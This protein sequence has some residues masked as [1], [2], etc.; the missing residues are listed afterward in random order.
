M[1]IFSL[2][3][4]CVLQRKQTSSTNR[5]IQSLWAALGWQLEFLLVPWDLGEQYFAS[6]SSEFDV[7][8]MSSPQQ[9]FGI[10]EALHK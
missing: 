7:K 8:M 9:S 6:V 4:K 3:W 5:D 2:N 10:W 1:K